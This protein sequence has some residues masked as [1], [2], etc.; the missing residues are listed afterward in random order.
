MAQCRNDVGAVTA[1]SMKLSHRG[2]NLNL[3]AGIRAYFS[4]VGSCIVSGIVCFPDGLLGD[5]CVSSDASHA[6]RSFN[7]LMTLALMW[8]C[9]ANELGSEVV[10]FAGVDVA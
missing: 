2:T 1:S 8:T 7:T 5:V 4:V 9:V 3:V 10:C 6:R